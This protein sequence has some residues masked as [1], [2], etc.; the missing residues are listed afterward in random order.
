MCKAIATNLFF[1]LE[2]TIPFLWRN[3]LYLRKI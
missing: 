3:G 1:H 2:K